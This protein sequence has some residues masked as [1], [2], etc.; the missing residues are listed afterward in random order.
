MKTFF[1]K[2]CRNVWGTPEFPWVLSDPNL[3]AP[4]LLPPLKAPLSRLSRRAG[5]FNAS[6][7][8]FVESEAERETIVGICKQRERE[9]AV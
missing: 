1:A 8:S 4:P 5:S 2:R 6:C 7:R 9:Q 3:A